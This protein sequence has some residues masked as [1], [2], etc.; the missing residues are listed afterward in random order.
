MPGS[1]EDS[2][3]QDGR[4]REQLT[5]RLVRFR[6]FFPTTSE[7]LDVVSSGAGAGAVGASDFA[8]A[9]SATGFA[10]LSALSLS[11]AFREDLSGA[12]TAGPVTPLGSLASLDSFTALGLRPPPPGLPP[13]VLPLPLV[14]VV[15]VSV[16]V[17]GLGPLMLASLADA[18]AA[19][20]RGPRG[21][22]FLPLLGLAL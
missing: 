14:V 12:G 7:Y 10:A 1:V 18:L 8:A 22:P 9:A 20:L 16:S 5:S 4:V 6:H 11:A 3:G 13:P 2:R 19:G 15:V 17:L 21:L